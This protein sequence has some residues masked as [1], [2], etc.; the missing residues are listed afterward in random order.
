M[1]VPASLS[2]WISRVQIPS[3][4]PLVCVAKKKNKRIL[5][6]TRDVRKDLRVKP[7]S[8]TLPR[9]AR[10]SDITDDV[11]H[12]PSFVEGG[13]YWSTKRTLNRFC[14][15]SNGI[16]IRRTK[17]LKFADRTERCEIR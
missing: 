13:P 5:G 12:H 3:R 16:E 10:L 8:Q 17:I 6:Q 9:I 4:L 11:V 1:A 7:L 15:E 2:H 14:G